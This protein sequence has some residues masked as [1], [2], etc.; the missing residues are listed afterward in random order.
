MFICSFSTNICFLLHISLNGP[1]VLGSWF[2]D[3]NM[4]SL[5]LVKRRRQRQR[6]CL[7]AHSYFL[8]LA[9]QV[10]TPFYLLA[11][12]IN[13]KSRTENNARCKRFSQEKRF[14]M[15]IIVFLTHGRISRSI[16]F[17]IERDEIYVLIFYYNLKKRASAIIIHSC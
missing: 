11:V 4:V 12:K 8:L 6:I 3:D 2:R 17:N 10:F 5:D 15:I 13:P 7:S 14:I 16:S 9:V 1:H